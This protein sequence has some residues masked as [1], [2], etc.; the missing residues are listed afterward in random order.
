[1]RASDMNF[2]FKKEITVGNLVTSISV[3]VTIVALL[4]SW[5]EDRSLN[6]HEQANEVRNSAAKTMAKLERWREISLLLFDEI[7]P[8]LIETSEM[9][10]QDRDQGTVIEARDYLYKSIQ[11]SQLLTKKRLVEE[12]IETAYFYL[13]GYH[14][15]MKVRFEHLFDRLQ[16]LQK[17]MHHHLL[18]ATQAQVLNYL[19]RD[20]AEQDYKTAT[21]GDNLRRASADVRETS[22]K[23]I[24]N[25]LAPME[26]LLS[27]IVQQSDKS[28]LAS[29]E[30]IMEEG[31]INE[32][33]NQ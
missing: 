2:E 9:L 1:M 18:L 8:S 33:S 13:Y 28:L 15:N 23:E 6:M 27:K 11:H 5:S 19:D 31:V 26:K 29:P 7:Q 30:W 3:L 17:K 24:D 14:P 32:R 16:G 25:A 10:K 22:R 20:I 12:E 21:L 4:V